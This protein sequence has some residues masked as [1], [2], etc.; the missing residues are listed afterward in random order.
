MI[1]RIHRFALILAP[2]GPRGQQRCQITATGAG[3]MLSSGI[4]LRRKLMH[5]SSKK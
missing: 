2:V 4:S 1:P 5:Y 3:S